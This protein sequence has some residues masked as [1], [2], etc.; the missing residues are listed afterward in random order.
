[1]GLYLREALLYHDQPFPPANIH[2][3]ASYQ[4][5][6]LHNNHLLSS[7][8]HI[9]SF[10]TEIVVTYFSSKLFGC[11]PKTDY[12]MFGSP[13]TPANPPTSEELIQCSAIA[14]VL[15]A[16]QAAASQLDALIDIRIQNVLYDFKL[17]IDQKGCQW[18][19]FQTYMIETAYYLYCI[20]FTFVKSQNNI[21]PIRHHKIVSE[22]DLSDIRTA[23]QIRKLL[24]TTII[25]IER[26]QAFLYDNDDLNDDDDF[27]LAL[28]PLG[29][30]IAALETTIQLLIY[31]YQLNGDSKDV[32]DQL[33]MIYS[34]SKN[35]IWT[36]CGPSAKT[37]QKNLKEFLK[38]QQIPITAV[39]SHLTKQKNDVKPP[40]F[41]YKNMN[42]TDLPFL[43]LGQHPMI[44]SCSSTNFQASLD[45]Y[46]TIDSSFLQEFDDIFQQAFDVNIL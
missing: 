8:Y 22:L 36:H 44:A 43:F 17:F 12:N 46:P 6:L 3:S 15:G 45:S 38:L 33:S 7:S 25:L 18:S 37:I 14:Q 20:H 42:S 23:S 19:L 39:A 31:H 16:S 1:M 5:D 11:L 27:R 24:P 13:T 29:L 2:T 34:I 32:Q 10:H 9:E 4:Y 28:L 21:S 41:F 35:E 30:M 26:L 40:T